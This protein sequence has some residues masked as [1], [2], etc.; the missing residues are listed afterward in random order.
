M[1]FPNCFITFRNSFGIFN[2]MSDIWLL[3][4][5]ISKLTRAR[6]DC[7]SV[8]LSVSVSVSLSVSVSVV[9]M[10]ACATRCRCVSV[11]SKLDCDCVIVLFVYVCVCVCVCVLMCIC[12]AYVKRM[13]RMWLMC[14]FCTC[15]RM[16]FAHACV[17]SSCVICV[18]C[19]TLSQLYL[20]YFFL[21]SL[22]HSIFIFFLNLSLFASGYKQSKTASRTFRS[23][24]TPIRTISTTSVQSAGRSAKTKAC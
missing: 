18:L 4:R 22:S 17:P 1:L 19:V 3:A 20:N 6:C 8:S 16:C 12:G 13:L 2:L 15:F 11:A 5:S 10:Y 24:T 23:M 9:S 14:L 7:V 21:S